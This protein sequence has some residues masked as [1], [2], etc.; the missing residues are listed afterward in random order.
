M[1]VFVWEEYD[2][3]YLYNVCIKDETTDCSFSDS[4]VACYE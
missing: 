2:T 1:N 4:E 3:V